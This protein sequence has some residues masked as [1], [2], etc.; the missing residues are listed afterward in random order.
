G[1]RSTDH[2]VLVPSSPASRWTPRNTLTKTLI[3]SATLA[4]AAC[5]GGGG[6]DAA[7]TNDPGLANQALTYSYPADHQA[8]IAPQAPV[9]LRFTRAVDL[10]SA[11]NAITL[12][13]GGANG[14]SVHYTARLAPDH[15][16]VILTP[17]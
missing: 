8:A 5:G 4:L 11:E 14:R 2:D 12:H 7:T 17:D 16:G 3:L 15:N 10:N 13:Q 6:H 9:V 1:P